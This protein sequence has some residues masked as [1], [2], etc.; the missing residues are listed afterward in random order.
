ME[1]IKGMN[2]TVRVKK[3][4]TKRFDRLPAN[5]QERFF[6]LVRLLEA[7]GPTA[8]RAFQNYSKLSGNEYHCHLNYSYVACWRHEK[9]TIIIE[10]YYVGSREDAPY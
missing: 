1:Y 9:E 3:T 5:V 8:G 6:T 7:D 4:V 2:Y 10:V